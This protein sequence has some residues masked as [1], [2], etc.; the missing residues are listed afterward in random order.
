MNAIG[1]AVVQR[2]ATLYAV[3]D[4]AQS[5]EV[6]TRE[7]VEQRVAALLRAQNVDPTAPAA[8]AE[9]ACALGHG[10]PLGTSVRSIVRFETP[11][12]SR[13]P[14][15]VT[16][17]IRGGDFRKAAVGACAPQPSQASQA[18]F[19]TYRVAILLY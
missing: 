7:E 8:P 4:F 2:G 12:L 6:L 18:S 9:Q 15:Q 3:E 17:Q 1:I 11:D 13:L 16:I 10:I 14:S 5:S 19:T